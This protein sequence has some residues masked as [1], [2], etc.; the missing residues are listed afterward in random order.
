LKSDRR[1]Q[2]LNYTPNARGC[3]HSDWWNL[4]R[5]INIIRWDFFAPV[6]IFAPSWRESQNI[7]R[8]PPKEEKDDCDIKKLIDGLPSRSRRRWRGE[9]REEG[10]ERGEKASAIKVDVGVDDAQSEIIVIFGHHS[11]R[12]EIGMP[13]CNVDIRAYIGSVPC[14][15]HQSKREFCFVLFVILPH[16]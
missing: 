1:D 11:A 13:I 7:T 5:Q 14:C 10:G 16:S 15:E 4:F 9:G 12:V 3:T 8:Q 6:R 2:R